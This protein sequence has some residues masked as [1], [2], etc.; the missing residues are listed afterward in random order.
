MA[1]LF[2]DGAAALTGAV[3]HTVSTAVICFEL[4]G[5]IAHIL[6]MMV[7]VILANMVA[8]SL[9]PSLYDSIIQVKKL[10]YLPDLGWNQLSKFTIF[11]E[12]IM[13]RD[14]KFVSASCTYGELR[15]LLQTTTV[16]TLPLVDSK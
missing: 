7:A 16:K 6:P 5:Q 10:P 12:D 13:V 11:V 4:T 3:S 14:V 9:Q 2:P 8:Q 15:N 1:M